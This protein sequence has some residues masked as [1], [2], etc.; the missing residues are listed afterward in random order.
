MKKRIL[1]IINP[2]S[3]TRTKDKLVT[4]IVANFP[5]QDFIIRVE[6]T[7][8]AG[9]AC[10]L[11]RK[12]VN[13]GYDIVVA[14]GGD[15]TINEVGSELI[16][17]ESALG[18][19]PMGSG[20]G[21]ARHLKIPLTSELALQ[22]IKNGNTICIDTGQINDRPFIGIAGIGF[23]AHIGKKF[24]NYGKR[25]FFTYLKLVLKEFRNFKE[26]TIV[27][28]R[29]GNKET[30]QAMMITIANS[31]QFGNNAVIAPTAQLDDGK[32]KLC[33]VRKFPLYKAPKIAWLMLRK[34][35]HRSEYLDI[36]EIKK[37]TIKQPKKIAHLDGEPLKL[38]KKIKIK[39]LPRSLKVVA[40]IP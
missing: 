25:G 33:I 35:I 5:E 34:Q 26:K 29:K 17:S 31:S 14:C 20:N 40:P 7:Q 36:V 27:L 18:I 28:K 32:L 13:L 22:T 24:A 23:D 11:A 39:V 30:L 38:G 8:Y 15:G 6:F 4:Q 1:F 12:A 10:L 37:A 16:G 9:H 21:L 19:I 2:I 3:G